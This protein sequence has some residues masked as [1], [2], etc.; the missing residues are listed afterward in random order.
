MSDELKARVEELLAV[1]VEP[2]EPDD[3]RLHGESWLDMRQ[4]IKPETEIYMAQLNNLSELRGLSPTVARAYLES[5]K[6]LQVAVEAIELCEEF[7]LKLALCHPELAATRNAVKGEI[8]R[9][10][11]NQ[12]AAKL[13]G[14]DEC[15]LT[16][17]ADRMDVVE[18]LGAKH[19]IYIEWYA[20]MWYPAGFDYQGEGFKSHEEAVRAALES[21][22]HIYLKE[23]EG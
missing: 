1:G 9:L 16:N 6:Q 7:G 19:G 22:A 13:L 2:I 20:D 21:L 10:K 18:A 23:G 5:H 15:D 8:A 3:T 17:K 4:R 11:A 12:V 14:R